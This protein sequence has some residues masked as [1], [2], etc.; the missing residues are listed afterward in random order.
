MSIRR[1][2]PRLSP[3][4]S[5][6]FLP[7]LLPRLLS[8]ASLQFRLAVL[9][10]S[11]VL[12]TAVITGAAQFHLSTADQLER[13]G[14][15]LQSDLKLAERV[16][17]DVVAAARRQVAVLAATP[18]VQG[19]IRAERA[20]GVDPRDGSS[21]EIWK[22]RLATIFLGLAQTDGDLL[23]VRYIKA[24]D[25]GREIVR[26]NRKDGMV[27]RVAERDLQRKG[28]EPYVAETLTAPKG[29]VQVFDI[30]LNRE[31]G[32]IELPHT[33][34]LRVAT[35]VYAEDGEIYG[36][37]IIN[38]GFSRVL[39]H[40]T[41]LLSRNDDFYLTS[42][43]GDYL[44]RPDFSRT[45]GF[46]FGAEHRIQADYPD[47][48]AFLRSEQKHVGLTGYGA[49][50]AHIGQARKLAFDPQAP[51]RFLLAAAFTPASEILAASF[52]SRATILAIVG[53]LALVNGLLAVFLARH[54]ARPLKAL[55]RAAN[56]LA[57]GARVDAV[58]IPVGRRDEVGDLARSFL[59]MATALEHRQ[60]ALE[61]ANQELTR[62]N[63]E[64]RDFAYIA[65]HDL[66]EPIRAASAHASMLLELHRDELGGDVVRRL[67][68]ICALTERMARLTS[69]LLDYSRL[70]TNPKVEL[71]DVK[72]LVEEIQEDLAEFIAERNAVILVD[73]S[74]PMAAGSAEQ[75]RIVLQN[76]IVNGIK[77][78]KSEIPRI[79]I[80]WTTR[81]GGGAPVRFCV[82]DNG[83]GIDPEHH[84]DIFRIFK[85]LHRDD[86]FGEG[87]GVGLTFVKRVVEALG[88]EIWLESA[89]GQGTS[90]FFTNAGAAHQKLAPR[91]KL[92]A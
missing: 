4:F 78:N 7:R 36:L 73:E 5:P 43:S 38:L 16:L 84:A 21:A 46:E 56:Q 10:I 2:L 55:T 89:P 32:V 61:R 74:L 6:R 34:V 31:N 13:E 20:G 64:L 83:V 90:F 65:S 92:A 18:P 12:S 8:G 29:A 40:L 19:L 54:L 27:S 71:V 14:E 26:V 33:P 30:N 59:S 72:R 22:D 35:P 67:G 58:N 75:L 37:I 11:L 91:E 28:G 23:Q 42:Q 41:E 15:R 77:Y 63:A 76:L 48:D 69:S 51:D 44:L 1:F 53:L 39:N 66:R 88:G 86:A 79:E 45:F 24:G 60:E 57:R 52:F 9:A 3:R 49:Q 68:R 62:S 85:R 70:N 25:G 81:P 80:G 50:S 47:V 17:H 82:R 87:T